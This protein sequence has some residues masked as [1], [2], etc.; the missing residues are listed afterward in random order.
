MDIHIHP[1]KLETPPMKASG[2]PSPDYS[3]GD[4]VAYQT[5]YQSLVRTVYGVIIGIAYRP[6]LGDQEYAGWQYKLLIYWASDEAYFHWI[7]RRQTEGTLGEM[8]FTA[9]ELE[10]EIPTEDT[11]VEFGEDIGFVA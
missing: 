5:M 10:L 1:H 6:F 11:Q 9:D 2:L 8:W 3:L 7:Q 4:L